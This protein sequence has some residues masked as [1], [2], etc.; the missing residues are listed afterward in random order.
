MASQKETALQE[1]LQSQLGVAQARAGLL[2]TAIGATAPTTQFGVL[3]NPQ[4]GR[5]IGG[6]NASNAAALGGTIQ[7]T[8]ASAGNLTNQINNLKSALPAADANFS[9]LIDFANKGGITNTNI[10]ILSTLNQRVGQ[11]LIGNDAVAGFLSKLG[12]VRAAYTA[13][14][15]NGDAATAIPD[16]VT[17]SQLQTIQK[18]LKDTANNNL[19]GYQNQLN[20]LTS[21]GQTQ[22]TGS[23]GNIFNW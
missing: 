22:T 15:G 2:G 18:S 4:T 17:L 1:Q 11:N 21:G 13:I 16:T 3:T 7:A 5:P 10:P 6:G 23:T 9:Q 12:D 8:Q 14:T 20:S 19:A